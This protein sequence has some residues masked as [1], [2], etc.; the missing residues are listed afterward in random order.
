MFWAKGARYNG[1]SLNQFR[2]GFGVPYNMTEAT[3]GGN[4]AMDQE[5]SELSA[6]LQSLE[7]EERKIRL[8]L[9][10]HVV[11]TSFHIARM[12]ILYRVL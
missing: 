3:S 4:T 12:N 7:L 10:V 5:I 2:L 8:R 1:I 9:E 6:N 11:F